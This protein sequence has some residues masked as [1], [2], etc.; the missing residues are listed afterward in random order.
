M[1]KIVRKEFFR[2]ATI[3]HWPK[4]LTKLNHPKSDRENDKN[5][6]LSLITI[7]FWIC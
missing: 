6:K 2:G 1:F 3:L 7:I 4:H 5:K